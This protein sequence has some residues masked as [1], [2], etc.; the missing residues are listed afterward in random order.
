V[1]SRQLTRLLTRRE[2][3][4]SNEGRENRGNPLKNRRSGQI[5]VYKIQNTS[6]L[7]FAIPKDFSF[8]QPYLPFYVRETIQ[9]GG[10]AYL[11]RTSEGIVS[12]LF[13]YDDV[14]KTGAIFTRSRQAFDHFYQL[15]PF[16]Y[17]F[18]EMKTEHES[19]VYDIYT[20][21]FKS[22]DVDHK[23]AHEIS[24]SDEADSDQLEQFM[25][26]SHPGINMRWVKVALYE[27]EKC[28][29][30]RLNREIGGLGWLSIVNGAGRLHSLF[31][32][33][34]FR[35]MGIGED[36]LFARLL[37]LKAKHARSAFSEISRENPWSS[38]IAMKGGMSV[39]GQVF[40]Y[41]KKDTKRKT[42]VLRW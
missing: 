6:D 21:D 38:R 42:R 17:L 32:R 4:A 3:L 22:N 23:F 25:V 40:Q 13:I 15:K 1:V 34:Q 9:I 20:L 2:N 19:E 29:M 35:R 11:S 28:F 5:D 10:E 33:P 36:I 12:G 37:W 8:F 30:V 7:D 18:S 24:L 14:E 41:F 16:N 31:V 26:S 39:S 27:G